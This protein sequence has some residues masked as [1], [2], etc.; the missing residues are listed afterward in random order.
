MLKKRLL[1]QLY[2]SYLLL[3]VI[4]VI[5]VAWYTSHSLKKFYLNQVAQDLSSRTHLFKQQ[6][7]RSLAE[8][9]FEKIDSLCKEAGS[10]SATRLTVIL[11]GGK[12]IGDSDEMTERMRNHADRP[13]I[14]KALELGQGYSLRFSNTLGTNMMYL[15]T[16]LKHDDKVIA[17][18]RASVPISAIDSELKI[19]YSKIIYAVFVAAIITA[20]ISLILSRR[21]SEPIETIRKTADRFAAGDL[22]HRLA[23]NKPTEL[24]ILAQA[25]NEMAKQLQDR[26]DTITSQRNESDIIL[27]NMV[28]GVIAI[29]ANSHIVKINKAASELLNI[30]LETACNRNLEEVIR[31]VE[32]Q[33]IAKETLKN[34]GITEADILI[35]GTE[36][37][38]LKSHGKA[39]TDEAGNCNGAVI[40]LADMTRVKKLENIRRDFVA[41]V[42]HELKTPITSIKGFVETLQD[43]A[44]K[45]PEE[46]KRFL[47]IVSKH[48]NRLNAIVDDLLSLSRLE[49]NKDKRRLLFE[50]NS[51][52]KPIEDAIELAKTKADKKNITISHNCPDDIKAKIDQP[53][54]EQA[55]LNLIDNAIKYSKEDSEINVTVETTDKEV[56]IY[57]K[58]NGCGISAKHLERI[59]ERFYVVD[60][61]RS[62][63]LGSTGLGLAIVK[64]IAQVHG[65]YVEVE[66]KPEI[67]STFSIHLTKS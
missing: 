15:A 7:S 21:I 8:N 23:I 52:K 63:K 59:F 62:R 36:P 10:K 44:I 58:D 3:T 24:A 4:A 29:D 5:A 54:L 37:K 28:E 9:N 48:A 51:V 35:S 30:E 56:S 42:S 16:S 47:Q 61:A 22:N 12:V 17:V 65:G 38:Y 45:N 39:L 34:E 46:T 13:E 26:I 60:K 50:M 49:E 11:P 32:I 33:K 64:H 53:L 43:G 40:V 41:N 18:V 66:S 19:I 27:S 1:W 20:I 67:G 2:P 14:K 55:V 57:V 6:I 31:N 25:M